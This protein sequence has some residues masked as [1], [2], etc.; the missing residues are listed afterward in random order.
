MWLSSLLDEKGGSCYVTRSTTLEGDK[1]SNFEFP[2][3]SAAPKQSK[4]IKIN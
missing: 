4:I 1:M 2:S 3:C